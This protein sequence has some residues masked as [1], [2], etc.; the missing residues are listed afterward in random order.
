MG[1]RVARRHSRS[2]VMSVVFGLPVTVALLAGGPSCSS[3]PAAVGL[4]SGCS[5]NSDCNS[6]LICVFSLCH[7]ACNASRDCPSGRDAASRSA[8]TTS[9]SCRASPRAARRSP[10]PV[11]LVCA[12]DLQC[13]DACTA[14]Q[15][16]L[17]SGQTCIGGACYDP[18]RP[19]TAAPTGRS[20][21]RRRRGGFDGRLDERRPAGRP[22][23]PEPGRRR[24]R[25]HAV[26]LRPG[27]RGRRGRGRGL[28][29]R[30]D[31]HHGELHEL[32][33]RHARPRSR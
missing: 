28:V 24:A 25:L 20:P 3:K 15:P 18:T 26:Q 8:T 29:E 31:Q 5:L 10:C 33:A 32:P 1:A 4:A 11:G 13:R 16:C 12:A 19:R 30:A 9:A 2:A 23:R 22:L 7:E 17:V 14:E 27:R 21:R 6:P